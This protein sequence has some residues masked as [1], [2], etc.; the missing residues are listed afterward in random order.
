MIVACRRPFLALIVAALNL[1]SGF[2]AGTEAEA[3]AAGCEAKSVLPELRERDGAAIDTLLTQAARTENAGA[4]L[5]R[6]ER[7]GQAPSHL[8]GTV[9]VT[10]QSLAALSKPTIDAIAASQVVALEAGEMSNAAYNQAMADGGKLMSASDKPLLKFLTEEDIRVVEKEIS[11]AGYP[12]DLALGIR[13]WVATLFLASSECQARQQE[14]GLKP[15]DLLVSDEAKS[16]AIPIV[17]LETMLE[18]FE[19]L[20]S[21]PDEEQAQWLRASIEVHDRLDDITHTMVELY[22]TRSI[23]AVWDLTRAMAPRI[24]ISD[25]TLD[26]IRDGLVAR[27]NER[28]LD[29]SLPHFDKGGAFVAVGAL[30]LIGKNGLVASLRQ[31]GY[32]LTPIE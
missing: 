25:A 5:W 26:V 12:P 20:A 11:K 16:R 32:S 28:M 10:H 1:V 9:H 29:R 19:T 3:A 30:H 7:D 18:Q 23:A 21:I 4:V 15:L 14:A 31:R 2:G 8:Y 13:P 27:R 24:K 22:Q 6:V 17:G